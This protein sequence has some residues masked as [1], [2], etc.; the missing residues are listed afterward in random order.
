MN[1]LA[2]EKS[3]KEFP[4]FSIKDTKKRYPDFDNR[5]LVEWQPKT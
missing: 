5:R 3:L 4:V 1:Y 2:F